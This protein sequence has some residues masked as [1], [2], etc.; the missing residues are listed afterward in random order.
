MMRSIVL[1]V[2]LFSL[3]S[4]QVGLAADQSELPPL[5]SLVSG[6]A[7]EKAPL[8]PVVPVGR[9]DALWL[10]CQGVRLLIVHPDN[11]LTKVTIKTPE[12]ALEFVRFFSSI[13]TFALLQGRGCVEITSQPT[14][15]M[16]YEVAPAE[17]KRRFKAPESEAQGAADGGADGFIVSRPVVCGDQSVYQLTEQVSA[18]GMYFELSRKRVLKRADVIGIVHV[19]EH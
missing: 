15:G 10:T 5:S 3:L 17:F 18:D 2:A 4:A 12:Q 11:L 7:I 14:G 16:F 9:K 8:G 1:L 19:S 13:P 6:C